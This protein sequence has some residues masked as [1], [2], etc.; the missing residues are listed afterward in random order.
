MLI[1]PRRLVLS[2]GG[3]RVTAHVGALR[4][5]EKR[6]YLKIVKEYIGVSAGALICTM[7]S[8]GYSLHQVEELCMGLDF[9]IMRSKDADLPLDFFETFGC[10]NGES[11]HKLLISVFRVKGHNPDLTFADAVKKGFPSLRLFATDLNTCKPIEFSALKTPNHKIRIALFASMA[12][13]LYFQPIKDEIT[14]HLL[15]DGGVVG[16]YPILHLPESEAEEC[17]GLTF[18]DT[19]LNTKEVNT[20]ADFI[21]QLM[22]AFYVPRNTEILRKYADRTIVIGCGDYPSWNFE[23][24]IEDRKYLYKFGEKAVEEFLNKKPSPHLGIRRYSV[25]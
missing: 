10:D 2:G 16:N 8:I 19:V 22:G 20:F 13:P 5:L 9:S 4:A 23:A 3:I 14:G 24:S 1:P 21:S 7:L 11:L 15:T 25:S 18:N 6:G 12:L 17:L